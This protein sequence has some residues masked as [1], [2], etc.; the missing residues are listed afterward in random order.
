M[1]PH[2]AAE[3]RAGDGDRPGH[4]LR[5]RAVDVRAERR[6]R[7]AAGELRRRHP[8]AVRAPVRHAVDQRGLLRK[9]GLRKRERLAGARDGRAAGRPLATRRGVPAQR[10]RPVPRSIVHRGPA[11][12]HS[13]PLRRLRRHPRAEQP[14][15]A[16][17]HA[18]AVH[19]T[20]RLGRG[21]LRRRPRPRRSHRHAGS[22]SCR[23][24]S[25]R[26]RSTAPR[27]SPFWAERFTPASRRPGSCGGARRGTGPGGCGSTRQTSTSATGAHSSPRSRS[28]RQTGPCRGCR[29]ERSRAGWACPGTAT[30]RAAEAVTRPASRR[31]FPPSGWRACRCRCSPR[32]TTT[33]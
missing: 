30:R 27:W 18:T 2:D 14:P 21:A 13:R 20:R 33:S 10:V 1:G 26:T 32:T 6:S 12:R 28:S 31:C 29:P 25:S 23:S 19:A 17:G 24:R 9:R 16:R 7:R 3:L 5:R 22:R 4:P 11:R 8:P 15:V